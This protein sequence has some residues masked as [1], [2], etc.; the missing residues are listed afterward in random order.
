MMNKENFFFNLWPLYKD[1]SVKVLDYD[2]IC[3]PVTSREPT[4]TG[5]NVVKDSL[6]NNY[7]HRASRLKS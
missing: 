4:Q 2:P 1:L 7:H 3:G 6:S 5:D